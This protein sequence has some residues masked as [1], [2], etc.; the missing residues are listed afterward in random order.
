MQELTEKQLKGA[1]RWACD[2]LKSV[3]CSGFEL[4]KYMNAMKNKTGSGPPDKEPERKFKF[5]S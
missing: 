3:T 5:F 4:R 2:N 1:Y